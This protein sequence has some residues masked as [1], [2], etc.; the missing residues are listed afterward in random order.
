MYVIFD[1]DET[2]AELYTMYYFIATLK[3][4]ESINNT[5]HVI[6]KSLIAS[7]NK[8]YKKFVTKILEQEVSDKPL[9]I[10]R[11]GILEV[12]TKLC[13]LQKTGNIKG[14]I[15]YS[16]NS[17]LQ[18]LEFIR[19]LIHKHVGTKLIKDCIHFNHP[20][21]SP[22]NINKTWDEI[23]NIMIKGK[24]NA[25]NIDPKTVYFFDDLNH[26]DLQEK[27]DHY[28][29][30]PPYHFKAPFDRVADIYKDAISNVDVIFTKYVC[31]IVGEKG[32]DII[33]LF[34]KKTGKTDTNPPMPDR[35]IDIMLNAINGIKRIK[36]EKIN[37]TRKKA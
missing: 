24:C 6:P 32:K 22:Q 29:K 14:V 17:H 1:L 19:D 34:K 33:K 36:T 4:K 27:L 31:D 12:M 3:L 28:Y 35:G 26:P 21:R 20:M 2:I 10:L 25:S 15:I 13:K 7:V 23:K 5:D 9:G 37:K 18:S 8:A 11:P 30:V 16:N